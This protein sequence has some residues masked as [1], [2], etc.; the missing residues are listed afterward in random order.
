MDIDPFLDEF[1]EQHGATTWKQFEDVE[2]W[3]SGVLDKLM[4]PNTK[5]MFNLDGVDPWA[6]IQRASA[7]RGQRMGVVAAL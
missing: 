6:G 7:G 4:D 2:Q 3:K 5:V 1:A